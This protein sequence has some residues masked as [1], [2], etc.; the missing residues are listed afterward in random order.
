M[1]R[2]LVSI[3]EGESLLNDATALVSLRTATAAITTAIG[4]WTV[5]G[6]FVLAVA[7]RA[8]RRGRDRCPAGRHPQA[9]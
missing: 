2:R 8:R 7:R 5:F 9:A 3:L 4:V 1:P 6:D